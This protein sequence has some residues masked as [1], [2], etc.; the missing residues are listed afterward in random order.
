MVEHPGRSGVRMMTPGSISGVPELGWALILV[1]FGLG[2]SAFFSGSETGYMSVSKVRLRHQGRD[3]TARGRRLL[4][5]LRRIEDPILTCLIGTNLFNVILTAIMTMVL[6]DRY[7]QKGEWLSVI[8]A[9]TLVIIFGEILPK[10]MYREFPESLTLASVSTISV[11]MVAMAPVRWVLNGYTKLLH[12]VLPGGETSEHRG[13]DRRSLAALLLGNS[14]PSR[15]DQRFTN[16]L[17]KYLDLA[18]RRLGGVMRPFRD[19]E[20]ITSQTTVQECL[21]M[22]RRSGFSRLPMLEPGSPQ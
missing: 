18:S 20:T 1:L 4:K 9:A 21:A 3:T 2:L 15:E 22:A 8:L 13:L 19:V 5:H 7:G 12:R 16:A 11:F 17:D 14:V 6:T 10:I